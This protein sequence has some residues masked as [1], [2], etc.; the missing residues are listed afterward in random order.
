MNRC[1][2]IEIINQEARRLIEKEQLN[3]WILAERVDKI[4]KIKVHTE[5]ELVGFLKKGKYLLLEDDMVSK[6]YHFAVAMCLHE[7]L[8][9][10][11]SDDEFFFLNKEEREKFAHQ[12]AKQQGSI[13]KSVAWSMLS[14]YFLSEMPDKEFYSTSNAHCYDEEYGV[15]SI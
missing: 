2:A 15:E 9:K 4:S 1:K 11:Y 7:Y 3:R 6:N 5:S 8:K 12:L 13:C 10:S 14:S